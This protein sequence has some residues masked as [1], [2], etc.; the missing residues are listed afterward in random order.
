MTMTDN[1]TITMTLCLIRVYLGRDYKLCPDYPGMR[2]NKH[3]RHFNIV[4]DG[5]VLDTDDFATLSRQAGPTRIIKRVEI[6]GV[7]RIAI[8][9]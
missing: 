7:S 5:K 3:G 8:Y 4:I 9:V 1:D 2:H 6:A